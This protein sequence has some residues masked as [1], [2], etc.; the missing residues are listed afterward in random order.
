[1]TLHHSMACVALAGAICIAAVASPRAFQGRP[2]AKGAATNIDAI[3]TQAS[4][5][6]NP[7]VPIKVDV[8][9]TRFQGD[10]KVGSL[11]F[12]LW[13]TA[14]QRGGAEPT[15]LRMGVDVPVG[16]VSQS[17]ATNA[18]NTERTTTGPDYRYVGTQIDVWAAPTE[19]TR[20]SVNLRLTDSSVFTADQEGRAAIK[21]AD[22]MAFRTFTTSNTLTMRDGQTLQ[23]ATATDKITGEVIK[24]DVTITVVK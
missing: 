12:T 17:R 15:S 11:P 9:L 18:N 4:Q 6:A 23:F 16:T 1:M 13:V 24:V 20:Y 19:D 3:V 21:A 7:R 5:Q 14:S 8:V 22:A 10:K 2:D